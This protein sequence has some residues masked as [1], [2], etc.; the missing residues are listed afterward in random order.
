MLW[1]TKNRA[2][3]MFTMKLRKFNTKRSFFCF[4]ADGFLV[5]WLT[6]F[7]FPA[8]ICI[9]WAIIKPIVMTWPNKKKKRNLP[10]PGI[11]VPL[12]LVYT[13]AIRVK[14]H[15]PVLRRNKFRLQMFFCLIVWCLNT[16]AIVSRLMVRLAIVAK[17]PMVRR[18][19]WN[20]SWFEGYSNFRW[21]FSIIL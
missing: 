2:S 4:S 16:K 15:S 20:C 11:N 5:M 12:C 19:D 14:R 6:E 17:L 9:L 21:Q 10:R 7:I 3:K 1:L 13:S 8:A 18:I